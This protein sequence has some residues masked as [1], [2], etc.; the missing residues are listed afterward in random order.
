MIILFT[1]VQKCNQ[2]SNDCVVFIHQVGLEYP[3]VHFL[4]IDDLINCKLKL[5]EMRLSFKSQDDAVYCQKY[6][7]T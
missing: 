1:F 7:D 6:V 4:A 5:F 3:H 2:L